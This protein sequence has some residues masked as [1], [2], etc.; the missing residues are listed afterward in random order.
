MTTSSPA[1]TVPVPAPAPQARRDFPTWL[2]PMLVKELRQGLRTKGFVG[3]LVG[4][5]VVMV[6][7]SIFTLAEQQVIR[8]GSGSVRYT[9]TAAS[10]VFWGVLGVQLLIMMPTRAL[11]GLQQEIGA[12]TIDLLMLTRL[13]SWRV[14]TGKWVS[15]VAQATL[16]TIA[17]LPYLVVRYFGGEIDL[18]AD[19]GNCLML[20]LFSA[21]LT[22]AALWASGVG[23]IFRFVIGGLAAFMGFQMVFGTVFRYMYV[24]SRTG[25]GAP[26]FMVLES[27]LGVCDGAVLTL[28][29]LVTAVRNIAPRAENHA[30]LARIL[31]L[32]AMLPVEFAE[33]LGAKDSA[34]VQLWLSAL[35]LAF[36]LIVELSTSS[37]PMPSHWRTWS[38]RGPLGRLVG[39]CSLPGWPS[40]MAYMFVAG[41]L[42]T[43]LALLVLPSTGPRAMADKAAWM[44]LLAGSALLFPVVVMSF[45]R[46]RTASTVLPYFMCLAVPAIL[47]ALAI[48]FA[49]SQMHFTMFKALMEIVPFSAFLFGLNEIDPALAFLQGFVALLVFTFAIGQSVPYWKQL[50]L[51][52]ARDRVSPPAV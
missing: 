21:V 44:A 34:Q 20:L 43:I 18:L 31:P 7:A 40:A 16:L 22:A 9:N 23:K 51:Y 30:F 28:F 42:W 5:Q 2:P 52:E 1:A 27:G 33:A 15:L 29:F 12:R 35:F 17:M 19:L 24:T 32:L 41:G 11:G 46:F 45:F 39:F 38:R 50:G 47:S 36:V 10:G 48:G 13:D 26:W 6:I 49:E 4:F 25:T 3:I 8:P 37:W 14:V